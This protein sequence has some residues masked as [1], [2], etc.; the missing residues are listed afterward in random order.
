MRFQVPIT[1]L[2]RFILAFAL[3]ALSSGINLSF[4]QA[5][6]QSMAPLDQFERLTTTS[7]WILLGQKLFWTS[8]AGGTWKN[9]GPSL[10]SE[11]SIQDVEFID[12]SRGWVLWTTADSEGSAAFQLSRTTDHGTTWETQSLSLFEPGDLAANAEKAQIG[13]FDAE[14]GWISVKQNTGSNFSIGVLFTTSDGGKTWSRSDLP[15]ADEVYFR[16]PQMGWAAGGPTGLELFETQDSGLTWKRIEPDHDN[17]QSVLYPPFSSPEQSLLVTIRIGE[18]NS[19]NAYT[20]EDA[21]DHWLPAG[22]VALDG[23][24]GSIGLSVLDAGNFIAT[25]PGTNSIVRMRD[26]DLNVLE[27][28]DGLSAS[29]VGLDMVSLEVGWAKSVDSSCVTSALSDERTASVSCSSTTRLLQTADGGLTWQTL[30]LPG[31]GSGITSLDASAS[32]HATIVSAIPA[33]ENTAAVVGQGFDKCEIPT[34]SQ[35]QT[36]S[37]SGPYKTVNLY[38]GGSSRACA[39]SSLSPSYLY[40]LSQ[41][42]WKFIPTWVG[43]Q[44][45]C[46]GFP[47]RMSSDPTVAFTQGVS[48]ANL[49]VDRLL[50]LGLTGPDKTGSVVYYDIENYGTDAA[51]RAAVNSFMNGWVSQLHERGNLAGVYGSTLCNTGLNDFMTIAEMPDVIWPARWYHNQGS[52]FYDPTADV[53]NLG[54]CIPNSAW[55]NHQRIRQYEGDHD[56]AW[57]GLSLAIDSDVLDGVV[58]VPHG[59][60]FVNSIVRADSDPT[61]AISVRFT[62][63]FSEAVTGVNKGDFVLTTTGLASA[64]I[65]SVSG[66]GSTYTVTVNTGSGN[67]TIRLDLV[68]NNTIG[69]NIDDPLGGV[70]SGNGSYNGGETYTIHKSAPVDSTGVFR[71]SNGLLYLKNNNVTGIADLALNYGL[72]G[73]YPVVGDWDGDG[74]VTIGIY[75]DGSFYLRNS[76]TLGFAEIVFPFGVSGDQPIAGDWDGDG[77]DTIGVYR[78]STGQFLLRNSNT[79]GAEDMSFYLGNVGDVGIAGDWDG[80]G[81]DTT[82][83]FRPSNGVIFLKS[84]NDTGFADI[85]L[86]YGLPGDQPVMGDWN[87]D[88][89]DT[90]GIYRNGTFYLRNSNTNGFAELIFGLGNPGDMPIAGNWDGLP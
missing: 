9:I 10:P 68:D 55:A 72:A 87:N 45:P 85:A 84:A 62:V 66:S 27:N 21:S 14:T 8:D 61:D 20:L 67:G 15:V 57:G 4:V 63:N 71:L 90:I 22:Q 11:G 18:A 86:N 65:L 60:P 49:A 2:S 47:S 48:E 64:S 77:I 1:Q 34:L 13:W 36:W 89:K 51:C 78:P 73:D 12:D 16:V 37:T 38:F 82:G 40:R 70:G 19:L 56:E 7:G 75:R 26:G 80:D 33:A 46:T 28:Q 52:G 54:N 35:M 39:N 53:W 58:A 50:A 69:D 31:G 29:I 44:A 25:I 42:G 76:N 43:P 6:S 30:N 24:P 83:V 88:G 81:L 3:A 74:I 17:G 23:Q 5:Q 32:T 41:Q 59:Y 79:E